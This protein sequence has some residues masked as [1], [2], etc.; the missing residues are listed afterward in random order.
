MSKIIDLVLAKLSEKSTWLGLLA[1]A[2]SAGVT[3][4]TPEHQALVANFGLA[5]VGLVSCVLKE[6]QG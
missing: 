4:L 2:S 6:R 1:L 3:F 5:L